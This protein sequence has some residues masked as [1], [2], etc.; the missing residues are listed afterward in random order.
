MT[1]GGEIFEWSH[2]A[3]G[4][5][6]PDVAG[7]E[8]QK[9]LARGSLVTPESLVDAARSVT[10]PLH[11]AFTWNQEEAAEKCRL[12]EA[13]YIF[14]H[15]VVRY[16]RPGGGKTPPIR[17][18]VKLSGTQDDRD[19]PSLDVPTRR[20]VYTPIPTVLSDTERTRRLLDQALR[21]AEQWR[22]RYQLLTELSPIF[23]EIDRV[24]Q[25]ARRE[26]E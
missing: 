23:L 4:G 8:I 25:G 6:R 12:A 11:N 22:N 16:E 14:R 10:S 3:P 13:Q 15:L 18:M 26:V 1:P 7:K 21:E 24:A 19:N 9:I 5:V 17:Y 2:H 20:R